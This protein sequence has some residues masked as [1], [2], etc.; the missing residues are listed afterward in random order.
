MREHT[1]KDRL[2]SRWPYLVPPGVFLLMVSL[3]ALYA[4]L[5]VIEHCNSCGANIGYGMGMMWL[6][7]W[8]FPWSIWPWRYQPDSYAAE[9]AAFTGCGLV[10]VGLVMAMMLMLWRRD[11]RILPRAGHE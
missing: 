5:A 8:G 1:I 4:S 3:G 6:A 11:C 7:V 10:N 2:P 9:I